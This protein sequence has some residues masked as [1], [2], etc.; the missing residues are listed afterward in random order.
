MKKLLF[1]IFMCTII[2]NVL[3]V[4]ADD[5]ENLKKRLEYSINCANLYGEQAKLFDKATLLNSQYFEALIK[6][7]KER[8]NPSITTTRLIISLK[9][10][11]E[12]NKLLREIISIKI[13]EL[14]CCKEA[15]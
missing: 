11:M 14:G 1:I 5:S 7:L 8:P 9:G 13:K 10:Q 6:E 2:F 15:Q 3:N 12:A 4:F